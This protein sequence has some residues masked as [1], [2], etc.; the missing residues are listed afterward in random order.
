MK[1]EFITEDRFATAAGN[2][3]A[4]TLDW[5]GLRARL[6]AAQAAR[7]LLDSLT[8]QDPSFEITIGCGCFDRGS[9]RM[10]AQFE[11]QSADGSSNG[12]GDINRTAL[13]SGNSD[14]DKDAAVAG[15]C[16]AGVRG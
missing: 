9:A 5:Q 3:A 4:V 8:E 14:W 15:A 12:L 11:A 6:A 10:L 1:M 7:P 16:S 2:P 13:A